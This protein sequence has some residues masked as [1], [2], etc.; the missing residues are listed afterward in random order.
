[1]GRTEAPLRFS[2]AR[3]HRD[4]FAADASAVSAK[5]PVIYNGARPAHP[6]HPL[7]TPSPPSSVADQT[8]TEPEWSGPVR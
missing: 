7:C 6:K 8:R 2:D 4:R 3:D 5:L 1:M